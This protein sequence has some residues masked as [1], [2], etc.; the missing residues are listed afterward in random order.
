MFFVTKNGVRK[1]VTK[2]IRP[3]LRVCEM[4]GGIPDGF[5]EDLTILGFLSGTIHGL[6]RVISSGKYKGADSGEI[7]IGFFDD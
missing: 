3:M 2:G 1:E 4:T 6:V 7:A 5:W